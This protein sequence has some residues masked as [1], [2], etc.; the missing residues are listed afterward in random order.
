MTFL[1][2]RIATNLIVMRLSNCRDTFVITDHDP[3]TTPR[4]IAF[5]TLRFRRRYDAWIYDRHR[6]DALVLDRMTSSENIINIY[7]Y[8]GSAG[9][10]EFGEGD[11]SNILSPDADSTERLKYAVDVA[12]AITDLHTIESFHDGVYSAIV[13]G[14]TT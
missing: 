12:N 9:L 13:H 4:P 10:F 3:A 6:M 8:C 5:K 14:K 2:F 11:M 1:H 7:G